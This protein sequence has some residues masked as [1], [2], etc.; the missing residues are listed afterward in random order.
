MKDVLKK[1]IW[2]CLWFVMLTTAAWAAEV[3]PSDLRFTPQGDGKF[4]YC[5][6]EEGISLYNLADSSGMTPSYIMNNENLTPDKYLLYLT[7]F[8]YTHKNNAQYQAISPGF[9]IELDVEMTAKEDT[10]V[11]VNRTGFETPL[12]IKTNEWGNLKFSNAD[13]GSLNACADMMEETIYQL[14]SDI[15]Y[16]PRTQDAKTIKIKKGETVWLS[17]YVDNY[18][19]IPYMRPGFLTA[20]VDVLSGCL[21]MNVVALKSGLELGDRSGFRKDAAFG[22]FKRDTMHKGIGDTLP[23]VN[24]ELSYTIDDTVADGTALPVRVY[25]QYHPEGSVVET[26]ITNI[27]PLADLWSRDSAAESDMIPLRYYD[28]SKKSFYGRNVPQREREDTW[29]F[30]TRHSDARAYDPALA[31]DVAREDYRPNFLLDIEEENLNRACCMGNFGVTER[32]AI[33]VTNQGA[34]NRFVEYELYTNSNLIVKVT[35]ETG[36]LIQ[37]VL[38]KGYTMEQTYDVMASVEIPAMSTRTFYLECTL[39][40]NYMGGMK[41]RLFVQSQPTEK[42][43]SEEVLYRL[44]EMKDLSGREELIAMVEKGS[45]EVKRIFDGRWYDYEV[46]PTDYGYMAR[47]ATWDGNPNFHR[48]VWEMTRYLYF[49][50]K[51]FNLTGSYGF[52][53]DFPVDMAYAEKTFYVRT[54]SGTIWESKDAAHWNKRREQVMPMGS[55]DN[56][57]G[58]YSS[59]GAIYAGISDDRYLPVAFQTGGPPF[60]E[61]LAELFIASDK[62]TIWL[63]YDGIYW[64]TLTAETEIK[65]IEKDGDVLIINGEETLP[66]PEKKAQETYIRLKDSY[67]S[68][69]QPPVIENDRTLVPM[70]F[71]FEQLGLEVFWDEEAR[72]ATAGKDG[73]TVTFFIDSDT[74]WVNGEKMKMDT[75]PRQ[76]NWR[77]LVPL[78]FLSE[79]LGYSVEWDEEN[80]L[81]DIQEP[82]EPRPTKIPET[83]DK[84]PETGEAP[85]NITGEIPDDRPAIPI[86]EY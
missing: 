52:H 61:T 62:N 12:L 6:N 64:N 29:Y 44:P 22:S 2:M 4:I 1:S 80:R 45:D 15:V 85:E 38:C 79:Q 75:V 86:E 69:D 18:D 65:T 33:T 60:V 28:P 68:F 10:T 70:R 41:N 49:F 55:A 40:V 21:D 31:G 47:W 72:A 83:D 36:A 78:R 48:P 82:K 35:D 57:F 54:Y 9:A 59:D 84:Q 50:D 53:D 77:T 34:Q 16:R 25:N 19:R 46:I 56:P 3:A 5:N 37:P 66:L 71:I 13:W 51:D 58:S 20:D 73:F 11:R 43:Y 7:H 74:A 24:A 30:D 26:W 14:H 39:P 23:K 63:S 42:E 8:N 32:Y 17:R 81:A 27:N 67:L 76:I